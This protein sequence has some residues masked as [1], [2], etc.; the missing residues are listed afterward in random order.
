ME[1]Q[2]LSS[3][4]NNVTK[5]DVARAYF[6]SKNAS[7][8]MSMLSSLA[9]R[10]P[11]NVLHH[12]CLITNREEPSVLLKDKEWNCSSAT[13][14]REVM[15]VKDC[16]VYKSFVKLNS[17]YG[18]KY[19]MNAA[20][21]FGEEAQINTLYR[22]KELCEMN[23]YKTVQQDEVSHQSKV[24]VDAILEE[25][26]FLQYLDCSTWPIG[27]E[28]V[29]VNLLRSTVLDKEIEQNRG[30]DSI[31]LECLRNALSSVDRGYTLERERAW[32]EKHERS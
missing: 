11:P 13:T 9:I 18:S 8:T 14:E 5:M 2:Q 29:R 7:R 32:A 27:L 1:Y 22:I 23:N 21:K 31:I 19:F 26:K 15:T 16:R 30:N 20:E 12:I 28:T 10:L 6:G 17:L 25:K 24:A 4:S 3:H